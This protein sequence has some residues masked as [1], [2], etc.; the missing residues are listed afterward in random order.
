[1]AA[2]M[3][4]S[5]MVI[6]SLQIQVD[7]VSVFWTS[8]ASTTDKR[9]NTAPP[10]P[11]ET[12]IFPVIADELLLQLT[13][14][15]NRC[16]GNVEVFF[17]GSW[18]KV[19]GYLWDMQDAQVVCRQLGCGSPLG[20]MYSF[21]SSNWNPYV[22]TEVNCA[23]SEDYL[24]YCPYKEEYYGCYQ[25]DASVICSDSGITVPLQTGTHA[26]S[27]TP[28]MPSIT[29]AGSCGGLLEGLSGSIQ[30]PGYPNPYPN[31]ARCVWHIRL[32]DPD[33]RVELQFLDVQL[34]G[35]SC[36]YDAIEVYDG[37]SLGSPLLGNICSNS[38]SVFNSSGPQ[39]TILFRSDGSVTQRGFQAYYSSFL[40]QNSTPGAGSCGGL[41]EGLS[42]SIQS[43]GYPNP[44]P[45]NARCVWHI[46]LWDPDRRVELQFLD[47]QL[48]GGSCQYDAI[49]V[50]DGGSLGS[51]LLGNV[52]SNSHSVFNSSG[53]Q[54][55]ILFRS[56]GSVTQR[57]FQA[58]YSSFLAQNSTPGAGSCGGLLEGLSG[59]IQSPGYPNPYPNNARCVWHIRLWDPDRRVELQFLDVQLEGGS[60]QYDAIE[61]YDGGSLGSPLLGNVCSN[62]HSVFNSSGP[63]LTILFRSDGSVTQRGFQAYYSSFLAQNSTP[64]AGSCGGLLE[65]LSGSIQSPGYPNPYPNNARCVWHIRLWDPD[66]RVE[67]QFLDVQLEG[68]SCQYDAIEVYDGG[69]LG[70]PLLGNVCSNSHSVF[71]SSGPQLTILFRSDGSVTQRGF[72]AYYSSFLAQNSTP[73]AGSCGGL[74]EGLSG[75]IQSPGYPNPY[76]NNARCVWHIRLWD[77]D[78][79]VE[80]Q[81]LDVQLEGGSCQYDAIE[82]YDGGSLGSP[83]L[84]NVCSNSHSVFNSSGPQLTIL[85]R[86]DG[87]VTQRGFQAYYSS[88]LA[89][90]ST[91][92]DYSCGGL[93]SSPSGTLQSPFYPKNYPNNANCVWEIEVKSNFRI[94]LTFRDVQ[95]EGGRCLSDYVEV[96][97]GPL[98]TS[99]LL[100]KFCSGS[101]RTYTSSSNLLTVR[102]YSNSQ[103]TYRGFQ[104]DYYSTLADQSTTLSC[105]SDYMHAVVSRYYLQSYGYSPWRLSL[106]DPYCKPNITSEYVIFDIPYTGCG[107]VRE[108]NNNT[109]IYSNIIRGSSS[110]TLITRNRTL[111]L[112]INC[113]MLQNTWAQRMYVAEDNF[114]VNETQYGRYDVNLTF[115][116]SASFLW[117]V[118][119]SPYCVDINQN[120]FLEAYLHSSDS[121]L[122]LFLDTCVASPTPHNFTTVT[123]DIIR[124]GCAQDSTY[125]T[126]YSPYKH[127]VRFKFSAFQFV[128]NN[129]LVYVQCELVVCRA[130]DYSSRCYQ[131][132]ISRSKREASSGQES[133]TVVAGPVQ[134]R[135]AGA[136]NGNACD[137]K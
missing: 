128:H 9:T 5:W 1:M 33:R 118:N 36:Q 115:Y 70:S 50:Y 90:N 39:L 91:P 76:P 93:L 71:N 37:G 14:G 41:L 95:M 7:A 78:R 15:P 99:P 114:E 102:F 92:E 63:Q 22:M 111:R 107:T 19:C 56:D 43:P 47:V 74:L 23:G 83:L 104:A 108:G 53:P 79:R 32:W 44:Y 18:T 119:E 126:Y 112:H 82:V 6:I 97:D 35:G 12:T 134:L 136:K 40:A 98:Y 62:S 72:Q 29:G 55:T 68:G 57:G 61:V 11:R 20:V 110:G 116:H 49:E 129:P 65:G 54:L 85:F 84:G 24:W 30:S 89:Q 100:G 17:F 46:R 60:C 58:Y 10:T 81:F 130:Y 38:H 25:R 86:S 16:A 13:G 45:N 94:T 67:L 48:E 96:Y 66:R 34:E 101:F 26:P 132:C 77:P 8:E 133:V 21:P 125:T 123:Y 64:G 87:S 2:T 124:N 69:S 27:L 120:L 4:L 106:N 31:N 105:L 135:G 42:G 88:F 131:G 127:M 75:S 122:V 117:P 113:K 59:S 103:Y 109:I 52:C 137:F 28:P 73:G 121:N 51:P 80:L 3:I